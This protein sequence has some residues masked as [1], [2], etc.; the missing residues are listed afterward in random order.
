MR[1]LH[2]TTRPCCSCQDLACVRRFLDSTSIRAMHFLRRYPAARLAALL[3][4]LF[5]HLFVW[6]LLSH[7]QN[8]AIARASKD[9][10]IRHG[11]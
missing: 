2:M 11:R 4:I 10:D 9:L 1:C 8:A 6:M 3:Y 5:L 7:L